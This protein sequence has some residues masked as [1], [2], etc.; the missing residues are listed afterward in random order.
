MRVF[1]IFFMNRKLF[2]PISEF[3]NAATKNI[4]SNVPSETKN[5]LKQVCESI[6]EIC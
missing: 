2:L 6:I 3:R 5:P 4:W 1:S